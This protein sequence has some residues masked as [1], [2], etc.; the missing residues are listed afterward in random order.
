LDPGHT[1]I[2]GNETV[3]K[4][5]KNADSDT[6]TNALDLLPYDEFKNPTKTNTKKKNGKFYGK[7]K[8]LN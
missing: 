7:A 1:D 3:D 6:D 4:F 2:I 8:L 5:A